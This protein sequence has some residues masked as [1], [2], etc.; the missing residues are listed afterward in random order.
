MIL[1]SF[2]ILAWLGLLSIIL[3][4]LIKRVEKALYM[5]ILIPASLVL[6]ITTYFTIQGLLGYPT[7]NYKET[8]FMVLSTAVQ[9]P[10]WI[11]YWVIHEGDE[12]PISYRIPYTKVDHE[13]QEGVEQ[14]M[15]SGQQMQGQMAQEKDREGG[16]SPLGQMEFYKFDFTKKVPK[17]D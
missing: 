14:Q 3:W 17:G 9:E 2:L 6:T 7:E 13:S 5:F 11:Y 10:D 1:F 15:E 16:G 4:D 12:E 8:K